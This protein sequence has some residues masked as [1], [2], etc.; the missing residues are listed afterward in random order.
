MF[1]YKQ[2]SKK[3][4][5]QICS[6]GASWSSPFSVENVGLSGQASMGGTATDH[7]LGRLT[8]YN[9]GISVEQAPSKYSRTKMIVFTPRFVIKNTLAHQI[10]LYEQHPKTK[11]LLTSNFVAVMP[12]ESKAYHQTLHGKVSDHTFHLSFRR[13]PLPSQDPGLLEFN[14]SGFFDVNAVTYFQLVSFPLS[15]YLFAAP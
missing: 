9:V 3:K 4:K 14:S 11:K 8:Q 6:Q 10:H 12:G 13:I 15:H 7:D 2:G 1:N 5:L